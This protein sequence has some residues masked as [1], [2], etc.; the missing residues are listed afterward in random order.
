M[1]K[2]GFLIE[3]ISALITWRVSHNVVDAELH[4]FSLFKS[5]GRRHRQ[6]KKLRSEPRCSAV[7]ASQTQRCKMLRL[8][9]ATLMSTLSDYFIKMH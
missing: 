6:V 8:R 3:M 7:A 9:L 2:L 4:C 1:E 5:I